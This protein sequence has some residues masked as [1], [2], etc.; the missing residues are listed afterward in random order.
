[1]E[2]EAA[3]TA[4]ATAESQALTYGPTADRRNAKCTR[5]ETEAAKAFDNEIDTIH[6]CAANFVSKGFDG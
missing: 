6:V 4:P 3:V 5:S 1:M 2:A